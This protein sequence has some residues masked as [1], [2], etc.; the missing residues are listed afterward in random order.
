MLQLEPRQCY[1]IDQNASDREGRS[2][3]LLYTKYYTAVIDHFSPYA[4]E[5]SYARH[6]YAI[7]F[8]LVYAHLSLVF[9]SFLTEWYKII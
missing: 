6:A 4:F 8:I 9:L 5:P 1:E 7:I 2:I 3:C